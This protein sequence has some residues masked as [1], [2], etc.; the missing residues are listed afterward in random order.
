MPIN[1]DLKQEIDEIIANH[2]VILFMKG[3]KTFPMCGFS[4]NSVECL[5]LAGFE[6]FA[7][8]NILENEE[9][10][11][12]MKEYSD[13]PTYPQLYIKGEFIGGADIIKDMFDDGELKDIAEELKG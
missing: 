4:A 3:N 1:A 11:A 6:K 7:T 12:A 5:T 2:S 13:W 10:R 9:L 8:I